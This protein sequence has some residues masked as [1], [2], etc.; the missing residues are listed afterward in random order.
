MFGDVDDSEGFVCA[1]EVGVIGGGGAAAGQLH[2][3]VAVM[4]REEGWIES[5]Y[6]IGCEV[7]LG[8]SGG[9]MEVSQCI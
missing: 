7:E 8:D 1:S 3:K 9:L 4:K 2:C 6:S 5:S